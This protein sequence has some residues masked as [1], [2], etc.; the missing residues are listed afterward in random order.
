[1]IYCSVVAGIAGPPR[2]ERVA[3]AAAAVVIRDRILLKRESDNKITQIAAAIHPSVAQK[4]RVM[5]GSST[6]SRASRKSSKGKFQVDL[7]N[8]MSKFT[9]R[10]IL[11]RVT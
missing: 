2:A 5:P 10:S 4:Q 9:T 7:H 1:M 11:R 3:L 6:R 8:L